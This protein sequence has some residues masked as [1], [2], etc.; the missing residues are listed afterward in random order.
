MFVAPSARGR[1]LGEA[2]LEEALKTAKS[3]PG[4]RCILLSVITTQASARRLYT[5]AGFQSFGIEPEALMVGDRC[6]DEEHMVL[7][8]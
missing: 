1:G 4:L 8:L 3:I 5:N 2:L 7:R 6:I